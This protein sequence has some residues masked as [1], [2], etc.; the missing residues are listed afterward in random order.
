MGKGPHYLHEPFLGKKDS[1]SVSNAVLKKEVST[2]GNFVVKFEK[3]IKKFTKAKYS[4]ALINCTQALFISLKAVG[5]KKNDEVLVPS[6]TFIGTV[7][8]ISYL[9]AEPHFV[10][11]NIDDFGIDCQKLE[12]YLK[13]ITF[14][15]KDKFYN[16][17]TGKLIS[18]IV[19]V[20]VFG[21]PCKIEYIKKIS[22][23]YNLK[24]VED[25]A[26]ALGSYYKNKHLGTFGHIGCLSFNGNKIITTGGGGV[27]ITNNL[28][29]YK[30]I[31]HLSSTAKV[32]HIWEYD[33]DDIGY[34]FR[35]PS[36]NASLG[37]A[38]MKQ[39]KNFIKAK[40][41]LYE[42]YSKVFKNF[43]TV[44]VFKEKKYC[45]SNYWLQALVLEKNNFK[46]K[47]NILKLCYK[48]KIFVRP[49]WK[50]ISSL[51]PYRNK[52]KM[53]LTGSKHIYKSVLNLPSSQ[54]IILKRK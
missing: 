39:I 9:D 16:K 46:L 40:R 49:V 53:D 23:K 1:N 7:N 38:Q 54:K 31:K 47:K 10:D 28:K 25:A 24:I 5:V 15:K 14:K 27:I 26:E 3:E 21:H 51:K 20:H 32:K 4:V 2:Y 41:S 37:L 6:L 8:A 35:M 29:L 43:N 52:Q 19:P 36:L 30:R 50:L 42:R 13:K 33:H 44:R 48:N 18:A 22:K 17:K 11:S 12:N 45:K 34:N